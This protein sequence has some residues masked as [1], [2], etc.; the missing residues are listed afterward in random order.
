MIHAGL[1]FPG[2]WHD[3][4][5]DNG[6]GFM[7]TCLYDKFTPVVKAV[8]FHS[9]FV[10]FTPSL[11]GKCVRARNVTETRDLGES[12]VLNAVVTVLQ[13]ILPSERKSVEWRE[14]AFKAPF[15]RLCLPLDINA[16]RRG[17]LLTLCAHLLN[18]RTR[19][20]GINQIRTV[21][22]AYEA[23]LTRG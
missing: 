4:R 15:G 11:K 21:Y 23:M 14:R 9:A 18:L 1:T 7:S 6:S 10:V 5:I 8:L 13:G 20:L 12:E 19:R 17:R 22:S 16:S 2:S 3:I